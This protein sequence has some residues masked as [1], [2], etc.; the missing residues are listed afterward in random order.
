M[1]GQSPFSTTWTKLRQQLQ[2]LRRIARLQSKSKTTNIRTIESG[3]TKIGELLAKESGL[4]LVTQKAD[5]KF[6]SK[7]INAIKEQVHHQ[8]L[9]STGFIYAI[10]GFWN[11]FVRFPSKFSQHV[12]LVMD[13]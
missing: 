8:L 12:T 7:D 2:H 5:A 10:R 13:L 6:L 3:L 1:I 11:F 9:T 4:P